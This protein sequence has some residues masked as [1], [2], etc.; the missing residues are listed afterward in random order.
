MK[1]AKDY[2]EI[3]GLNPGA[4]KEEI[5]K[6]YRQL[7]QM[8]HPDK[9]V[10]NPLG[11]LAE[12]KFKEI[13]E[14]YEQLMKGDTGGTNYSS[15]RSEQTSSNSTYY[16]SL[17]D[18]II[19]STNNRLW[20]KT[21]D[22]CNQALGYNDSEPML[23]V[24]KA[25]AHLELQQFQAAVTNYKAAEVNHWNPHPGDLW[26]FSICYMELGRFNEAIPII[27][28]VISMEG[29]IPNAIAHLA[30]CYDSVGNHTMGNHYWERLER[31]DPNNEMLS[32]RKQAMNAGNQYVS[33][34]DA[35]V[36]ACGICALLE[37]I[38]DCC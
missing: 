13:H 1:T 27:E 11:S 12:E 29:D 20:G 30:W 5:K 24:Y 35:A 2:Y 17:I 25:N 8:Y 15:N 36:G 33:R 23:Y 38:F 3:L 22:L 28:R 4:S 6:K 32:Q 10:G 21:I 31:I 7:A 26:N 18:Q 9:H 34:S 16:D 19:A 14:A 37:C